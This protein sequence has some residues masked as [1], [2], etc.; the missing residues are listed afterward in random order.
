MAAMRAG[1][2]VADGESYPVATATAPAAGATEEVNEDKCAQ[3][4]TLVAGQ[5]RAL[6]PAVGG[7]VDRDRDHRL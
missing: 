3:R 6:L 5:Q 2:P 7:L 4:R 1:G